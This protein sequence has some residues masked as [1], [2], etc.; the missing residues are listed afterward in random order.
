MQQKLRIGFRAFDVNRDG[1]VQP[2]E[3]RLMFSKLSAADTDLDALVASVMTKADENHD[4]ELE[5]DEFYAAAQRDEQI[6]RL[7]TLDGVLKPSAD[8]ADAKNTAVADS[9][10]AQPQ[11]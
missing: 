1:F 2:D 3:L 9:A 4:G 11:A 7:F 6:A 10:T 5:E 8:V